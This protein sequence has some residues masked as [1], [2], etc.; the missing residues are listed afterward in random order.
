[1][2]SANEREP[3]TR[4]PHPQFHPKRPH[5]ARAS[6]AGATL[7]P[8]PTRSRF[9][10]IL[11]QTQRPGAILCQTFRKDTAHMR[12]GPRVDER[13]LIR[14]V[15]DG[16]DGAE[17]ELYDQ[18]VDRVYRLCYRMANADADQAQDFTQETFVRAFSR[19]A[20]FRG[21]AALGTWLHSIAVSVSLNGMRRVK[22]WNERETALDDV[23][24]PGALPRHA[25]PDLKMKLRRAIA[26]LPEHYRVVFVMYDM[27]GYTH[28]EIGVLMDRTTSFSK[29]QLARGTRR[30]RALLEPDAR[31]A[32]ETAHV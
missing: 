2:A 10:A 4:F 9:R 24:E 17:R 23:A 8:T 7:T 31:P 21:A 6:G 5:P 28:E 14:R 11:F 1:M 19:L 22:R 13:Q 27:E 26:R 15:L 25:E 18:H 30:L 32:E 16:D 3:P 29:S 20:D 12:T